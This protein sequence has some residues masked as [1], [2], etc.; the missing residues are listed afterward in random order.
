MKK[1]FFFDMDGVL[2][3]SMPN[4]SKAWDIVMRKHGLDFT[5][6]DC[7]MQEGRTGQ[8]VIR[9]A[10]LM[11]ENREPS[12]EEIWSIYDEKTAMF[13]ELGGAKPMP[14][15]EAV[16][17]YLYKR[18]AQIWVVT[19]S[20]QASLLDNLNNNFGPFFS[21]SRMVTA[22][23]VDKGKPDPEPYLKAWQ[24]SGLLKN[25]CYVIENAP[26]GVRAGKAA[27]LYVIA[28]NTGPLADQALWDE[29][30]DVVLPDI[31]ALMTLIKQICE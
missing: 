29:G 8:D 22:F 14:G 20:G 19:G 18:E 23:D 4:H 26:L 9:E 24:G 10:F 7:Y 13:L 30:A 1:A 12:E 31:E 2:Y 28:V 17:R 16:L 15:M 5:A 3:D 11:C 27:G 25:Q 6:E 21:R